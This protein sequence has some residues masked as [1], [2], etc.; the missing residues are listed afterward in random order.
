V[1]TESDQLRREAQQAKDRLVGTVGELGDTVRQTRDEAV[2]K[3]KRAAPLIGGVV[4]GLVLLK[5]SRRQRD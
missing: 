3:V 5:L 2:A 4:V 1:S